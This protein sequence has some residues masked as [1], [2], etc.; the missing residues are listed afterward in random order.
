M[1]RTL[2]VTLLVG[3]LVMVWCV[4]LLVVVVAVAV[5]GCR[6]HWLLYLM[7]AFLLVLLLVVGCGV[8]LVV[9]GRWPGPPG[10]GVCVYKSPKSVRLYANTQVPRR[11]R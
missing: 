3:W 11:D 7:F 5:P 8:L 6:S 2:K 10:P 1:H 9:V 4:V